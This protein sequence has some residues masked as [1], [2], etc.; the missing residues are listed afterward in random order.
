VATKR[1]MINC[2]GF[3][4]SSDGIAIIRLSKE[5]NKR[6]PTSTAGT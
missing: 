5:P 2:S 6:A 4:R 3:E 1:E